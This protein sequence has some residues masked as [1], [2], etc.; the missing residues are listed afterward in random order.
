MPR[1]VLKIWPKSVFYCF[2]LQIYFA[3]FIVICHQL[4]V[5]N[6]SYQHFSPFQI[7][8]LTFPNENL[9]YY[10]CK[11][12]FIG[13]VKSAVLSCRVIMCASTSM[14]CFSKSGCGFGRFGE[15]T[16]FVGFGPQTTLGGKWA[17]T[18]AASTLKN[19]RAVGQAPWEKI[20]FS[21]VFFVCCAC[22]VTLGQ[23]HTGPLP[24]VAAKQ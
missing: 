10:L 1:K 19:F 21:R 11:M 2:F 8:Q 23:G 5:T 24:C 4:L 13:N 16:P 17:A 22:N 15:I 6:C 9:T 3:N 12:C 14:H 18:N 7:H 20:R